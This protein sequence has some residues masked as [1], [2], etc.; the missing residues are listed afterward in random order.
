MSR[1]TVR[2]SA[3][4]GAAVLVVDD[5]LALC[6]AIRMILELEGYRVTLATSGKEA[7]ERVRAERPG[8]VFLDLRM[9]GMDGLETYGVLHERDPELPVI[10]MTAKDRV[11][12]EVAAHH[13]AGAL[14]KPFDVDLVLDTVARFLP[15]PAP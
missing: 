12:Q 2:P 3:S 10:F 8:V 11:R 5:E 1:D 13:A 6:N 4:P 14:P 15:S 9:P 7:L